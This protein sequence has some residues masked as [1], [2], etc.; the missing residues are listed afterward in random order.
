MAEAGGRAVERKLT[1]PVTPASAMIGVKP[2][3]ARQLVAEGD[4][5]NF[6]VSSSRPTA[7]RWR[8][9]GCATSC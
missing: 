7:S 4:K 5:A 1:L 8:A 6:D 2:L 9:T 3:F